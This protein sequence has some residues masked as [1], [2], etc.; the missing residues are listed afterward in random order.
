MAW[1]GRKGTGM[2]AGPVV[3]VVGPV[4]GNGGPLSSQPELGSSVPRWL[5]A[6]L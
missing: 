3:E 1:P 2:E 6:H 5:P 4:P